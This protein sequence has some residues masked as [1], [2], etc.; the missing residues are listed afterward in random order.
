MPLVVQHQDRHPVVAGRRARSGEGVRRLLPL[1][2]H[3]VARVALRVLG[4]P[5][6]SRA[7][8]SPAP[9]PRCSSG[10]YFAGTRSNC[11]VVVVRALRP[12]APA[13]APSPSGSGSRPGPRSGS[14]R[15]AGFRPAVAERP[16]DQHRHDDRLAA[17]RSPSCSRGARSGS[18]CRVRRQVDERR[19]EVWPCVSRGRTPARSPRSRRVEVLVASRSKFL[20]AGAARRPGMPQLQRGR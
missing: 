1:V 15:V 19:E 17:A 8:S 20:N 14:P 16:R 5:A 6:R 12:Q 18:R 13:A 7:S 3:A 4:L 11:V 2:D 9:C 10:R